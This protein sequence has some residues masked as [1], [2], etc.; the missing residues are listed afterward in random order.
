MQDDVGRPADARRARAAL[1][2]EDWAARTAGAPI[3]FGGCTA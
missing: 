1:W 3:R 2:A